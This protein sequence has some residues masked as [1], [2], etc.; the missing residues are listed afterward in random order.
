M[1]LVSIVM[2]VYNGE[3]YLNEAIESILRQ[4]YYNFEFIII[5]DGSS[6]KSL[7]IIKAYAKLD[8]RICY[9]TRENKGLVA[10]LNEGISKSSGKYIV[11]MDA[12]DISLPNRIDTQVQYMENHPEI[13]VCGSGAEV[14]SSLN[15]S[16]IWI[17]NSNSDYLKAQLLFTPCFLHPAVIIRKSIL[18]EYD[19]LYDKEF[20]HMEDYEIWTRL[21]EIT[22]FSNIKSVLL[23]Y[24][25]LENSITRLANKDKNER[26]RLS[27]LIFNRQLS[28]LDIENNDRESYIHFSLS[29]N[30][31]LKQS[32]LDITEIS[33]YFDKIVKANKKNQSYRHIYLNRVLGKRWLYNTYYNKNFK[34]IFSKYFLFGILD[35]ISLK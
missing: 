1:A 31:Y 14:F 28:C 11:R 15:K 21:A 22:E 9:Y 26:F 18:E 29:S 35:I 25:V 5:D 12:D 27:R 2:S 20:K 19:I 10:S 4:T 30:I 6:D 16:R 33:N 8:N 32:N 23:K 34:S 24:R 13:G 17:R 3:K 7:E